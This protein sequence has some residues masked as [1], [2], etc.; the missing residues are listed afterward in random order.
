MA[1]P[2]AKAK[3]FIICKHILFNEN[4]INK[5]IEF[6]IYLCAMWKD[7]GGEFRLPIYISYFRE[8]IWFVTK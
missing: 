6:Q 1:T 2:R 8:R 4:K 5:N 3:N 7:G